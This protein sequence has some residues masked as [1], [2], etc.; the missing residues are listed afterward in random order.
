MGSNSQGGGASGPTNGQLAGGF[1]AA[2]EEALK[3]VGKQ[4]LKTAPKAFRIVAK[5]VPG[6]P[7]IVYDIG[8]FSAAEDKWRAGAEIAGSALGAGVGAVGGPLGAAAGSVAG[9]MAADYLYGHKDDI[10]AWMKARE[11]AIARAA[12]DRLRPYLPGPVRPF[13]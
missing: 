8:Q 1:L 2:Q 6:L 4:M 12:A 3:P 11:A 7:G 10:K 13:V 5:R 9:E